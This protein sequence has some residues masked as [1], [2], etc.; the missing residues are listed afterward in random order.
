MVEI[1]AK[2]TVSSLLPAVYNGLYFFQKKSSDY[3]NFLYFC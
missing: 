1:R 2:S 3:Y